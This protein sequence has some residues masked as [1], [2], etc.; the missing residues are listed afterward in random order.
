MAL[1]KV[2]LSG[3]YLDGEGNVLAG[4]VKFVPNASL[5]D[6]TDSRL[7]RPVPVVATLD[8]TGA[9]SVQLYSTD[10]TAIT[11][12]G[13]AW[14]VTEIITGIPN[15]SWSFFLPITGGSTQNISALTPVTV[16]PASSAYVPSTGGT[17]T[18]ALV[19]PADPTANLQAAT[20][21]YV[22][23]ASGPPSGSAGGSLAGTYPNPTLAATA[24]SAG[25]YTSAN[26]T[27]AADGRVTAAANGSGGS[28]GASLAPTAVKTGAYT[29]AASD[30][31]PC[32]TTSTAFTVTLPTTPADKTIIGVKLV[33]LG[34]SN[35][36]TIATGGSDVF[37]KTGGSTTLSL[38][39]ALQTMELQY[40]SSG[41]I[42]Y[43]TASDPALGTPLQPANNLSDLATPATARTNLGL[44]AAATAATLDA[45]PAPVAAVSLNSKKITALLAGT[46][47]T[48]GANWGQVPANW[49][50]VD[51]GYL[52]WNYDGPASTNGTAIA[53][54]TAGTVFTCAVPLRVAA[55]IG[56]I[57]AW[58]STA[59]ATLTSG[60]CFAALYQ[61][62]GGALLGTT[63]DQS[64]AW[65]ST[66][67]KAMTINGGT[68]VAVAAG[69]LQVVFWFNGTTGPAMYR[70]GATTGVMNAG[71]STAS[72]R[73][74]VANTGVTTTAPTPL[75]AIT[76]PGSAGAIWV[77][78]S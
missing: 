19:L 73:W 36:V 11:P 30:F 58:V 54:A 2:T 69:I 67:M 43:V 38:T 9:F 26:I 52:A 31:V 62:A 65:T 47:A 60:Q 3:T 45:I 35:A 74:G 42:W 22:D 1:T 24:V 59:G 5:T 12:S 28:G 16:A 72:S 21:H 37:N 53:F 61:G 8:G 15:R 6:V 77:A 64:T 33:T 63:A 17:M 55:S 41:A 44:G 39:R 46:A 75:G 13:W 76:G 57:S 10:N 66:G 7:I 23:T 40:K 48:D 49:G 71:Q 29:A 68:P 56:T 32:D 4:S 34:G 70:S 20:K 78:L 50:P 51:Q 14:T 25:S 27:V 18:G